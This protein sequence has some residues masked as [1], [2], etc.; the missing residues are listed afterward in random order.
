MVFLVDTFLGR[1]I[2]CRYIFGS[3]WLVVG[4]GGSCVVL[5]TTVLETASRLMRKKRRLGNWPKH[6]GGGHFHIGPVEDMPTFSISIF[7]KNS[8]AGYKIWVKIP[9]QASQKPMIF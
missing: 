6:P 7:S 5:E 9:E 1:G 8:R 3:W 2:S 4:R